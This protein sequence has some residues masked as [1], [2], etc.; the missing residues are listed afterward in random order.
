MKYLLDTNVLS[1]FAKDKPDSH[2]D[3]WVSENEANLYVSTLTIGELK[4]GISVLP[5]GKR[6]RV[7]QAWLT[8]TNDIMDGRILSFNRA[9]AYVWAEMRASLRKE[10][11][12]IPSIDGMIAAIAI[13]YEL[14]IATRNVADFEGVGVR[15]INP[16]E[17]G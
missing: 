2:V 16:F 7:L 3:K 5:E 9:V 6:K 15:L 10:G 14:A 11:R 17:A 4:Y 1:Q 13:R 8:R 12:M